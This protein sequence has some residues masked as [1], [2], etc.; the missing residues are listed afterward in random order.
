MAPII[1]CHI[2]MYPPELFANPVAWGMARHEAWWTESVA[3]AKRATIQGWA[4]M[5][6]LLADMDRAGIERC[7]MLGWY[8]EHQLTCDEQNGWFIEWVRQHP[9]RLSAFAAVQPA[10]GQPAMV[11]LERALD[12][13]L[14]GIG[15]ILPQAQ[16]FTFDD[17]YWHR[18]V[19]I[20]VERDLPINLHVTDP[21]T[22][23][24]A[25]TMPTPLLN[26]L[27]LAQQC[28]A[29]KFIFAHWGG[30]IPFYELNPRVRPYLKNVWY[31]TA[32]SPLLYDARIFRQIIDLIGADRI[33]FGSD[34]PLLLYPRKTREPAFDRFLE[35]IANA[36]LTEE[37]MKKILGG[38]FHRLTRR[39]SRPSLE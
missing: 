27:R 39:H 22:I 15:E 20:A 14:C 34:Y 3:P 35:E 23:S 32:A 36:G 4:D 9:D 29:A 16:G 1:D 24:D 25:V 10:A 7:V 12:A 11:A 26:Y 13:G 31:D 18:L 37:E 21:L 6:R 5:P 2:H 30:G 19:E 17:P 28:P 8:W 33:L 38:N